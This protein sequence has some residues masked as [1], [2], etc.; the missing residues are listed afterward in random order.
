MGSFQSTQEWQ[1]GVWGT[2]A[3]KCL[4]ENFVLGFMNFTKG[5][6]HLF[7]ISGTSVHPLLG[8]TVPASTS[9]RAIIKK[10]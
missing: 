5:F 7:S 1:P 4:K 8:L 2:A 6:L 10:K 3:V 9:E